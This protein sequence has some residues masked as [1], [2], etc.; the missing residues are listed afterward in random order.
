MGIEY[1]ID[2]FTKKNVYDL[3]KQIVDEF[4]CLEGSTLVEDGSDEYSL[5]NQFFTLYLS[6]SDEYETETVQD[7]YG[8][9]TNTHI[10][11]RL[12]DKSVESEKC[13]MRIVD[14]LLSVETSDLILEYDGE[15]PVLLRQGGRTKINSEYDDGSEFPFDI[16]TGPVEVIKM[17][18]Q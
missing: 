12:H 15:F 5:S 10:V 8:I 14:F 2:L 16:I 17:P 18:C 9:N 4:H 6:Y 13:M 1:N 7:V 3:L 11:F